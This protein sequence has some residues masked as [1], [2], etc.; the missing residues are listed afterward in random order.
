MSRN[1]SGAS[2]GG[3][4][5]FAVGSS[6][7]LLRDDL[8]VIP[9]YNNVVIKNG[10]QYLYDTGN[11]SLTRFTVPIVLGVQDITY[12]IPNPDGISNPLLVTSRIVRNSINANGFRFNV[13]YEPGLSKTRRERFILNTYLTSAEPPSYDKNNPVP[14]GVSTITASPTKIKVVFAADTFSGAT[15]QVQFT[16]AG[17]ANWYSLPYTYNSGNLAADQEPDLSYQTVGTLTWQDETAGQTGGYYLQPQGLGQTGS[18]YL[19]YNGSTFTIV[20]WNDASVTT[21]TPF[22]LIQFKTSN[23]FIVFGI[24]PQSNYASRAN[25]QLNDSSGNPIYLTFDASTGVPMVQF[26]YTGVNG[27]NSTTYILIQQTAL[28]PK[29]QFGSST[30][31]FRYGKECSS[32]LFLKFNSTVFYSTAD[33]KVSLGASSF[34]L[35]DYFQDM[36]PRGSFQFVFGDMGEYSTANPRSNIYTWSVNPQNILDL[37]ATSIKFN[38]LNIYAN[39]SGANQNRIRLTTTTGLFQGMP[40]TF[41]NIPATITNINTSATYYINQVYSDTVNGLYSVT[42]V[43]NSDGKTGGV[44]FSASWSLPAQVS[45]A[46]GSSPASSSTLFSLVATPSNIPRTLSN[47]YVDTTSSPAKLALALDGSGFSP[48]AGRGW[49]IVS[50]TL[51]SN[52]ALIYAAGDIN[53]NPPTQSYYY[54]NTP[55]RSVSCPVDGIIY[56]VPYFGIGGP[57]STLADTNIPYSLKCVTCST[58]TAGVCYDDLLQEVSTVNPTT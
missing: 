20:N 57:V 28:P 32:N 27:G 26:T 48:P 15:P 41:Q 56:T 14:S 23:D 22:Y 53:A 40:V 5:N 43:T 13:K 25:T 4:Q 16:L 49:M 21:V 18:Y 30:K 58:A 17:L 52:V 8:A 54:V 6:C 47:I 12:T 2:P 35:N 11:G 31:L 36:D 55:P 19:N 45:P 7:E 46:A 44:N 39:G 50:N 29:S 1:I 42:I 37:K 9:S 38:I 33:N 24:S 34:G 3:P 51:T 10:S